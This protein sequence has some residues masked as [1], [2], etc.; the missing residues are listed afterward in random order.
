MALLESARY[1]RMIRDLERPYLP[2][3]GLRRIAR[4]EWRVLKVAVRAAGDSGGPQELHRLASRIDRT[5]YAVE[6]HKSGAAWSMALGEARQVIEG[7]QQ[8]SLAQGWLRHA[9]GTPAVSWDLLAGQ[10]LERA[11]C[12]EQWWWGQWKG[13]WERARA[14]ELRRWLSAS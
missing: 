5:R 6:L 10:L 9:A 11:R 3:G 4:R 7:L 1:E 14:K 2:P 13:S 12:S 8:A